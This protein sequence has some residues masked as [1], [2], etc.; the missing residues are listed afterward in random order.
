MTEDHFKTIRMPYFD[1]HHIGGAAALAP[2]VRA[3]V[4][5]GID[6]TDFA[7]NNFLS[8]KFRV[9]V[10]EV[11]ASRGTHPD[12]Q[13]IRKLMPY[14]QQASNA[15]VTINMRIGQGYYVQTPTIAGEVMSNDRVALGFVKRVTG[16]VKEVLTALTP[17]NYIGQTVYAL[18]DGYGNTLKNIVKLGM[19]NKIR[20]FVN[21]DICEL[22]VAKMKTMEYWN[23]LD[24]DVGCLK[25]FVMDMNLCAITPGSHV[26]ASNSAHFLTR[27]KLQGILESNST[28]DGIYMASD[29]LFDLDKTSRL[30]ASDFDLSYRPESGRVTGAIAGLPIN[31]RVLVTA[32]FPTSYPVKFIYP[33]VGDDDYSHP[34]WRSFAMFSKTRF[35][36]TSTIVKGKLGFPIKLSNAGFKASLKRKRPMMRTMAQN[37]YDWLLECGGYV[38]A[39]L[40]GLA[41]FA[42]ADNNGIWKVTLRGGLTFLPTIDLE[43]EQPFIFSNDHADQFYIELVC[44]FGKIYPFFLAEVGGQVSDVKEKATLI[45]DRLT[46]FAVKLNAYQARSP[47]VSFKSYY[48]IRSAG[49]VALNVIKVGQAN[50]RVMLPMDGVI[51]ND[52]FGNVSFFY[53]PLSTYDVLIHRVD[54]KTDDLETATGGPVEDPNKKFVGDGIYECAIHSGKHIIGCARPDKF[55]DS[56]PLHV[57]TSPLGFKMSFVNGEY[58]VHMFELNI[59]VDGLNYSNFKKGLVTAPFE[60]VVSMVMELG[61]EPTKLKYYHELITHKLSFYEMDSKGESYKT[62]DFIQVINE[63]LPMLS[64][65]YLWSA[66]YHSKFIDSPPTKSSTSLFKGRYHPSVSFLSKNYIH[67]YSWANGAFDNGLFDDRVI[68]TQGLGGQPPSDHVVDDEALYS[69]HQWAADNPMS[70]VSPDVRFAVRARQKVESQE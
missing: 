65:H 57:D 22:K 25:A 7:N 51:V 47:M 66:L 46:D 52:L 63:S 44:L 34:Y 64:P 12:Y 54:P 43:G 9:F 42:H 16:Y 18:G 2:L 56:D 32:D 4:E 58:K 70:N 68:F 27:A 28:F 62:K 26:V 38:S 10:K 36:D 49:D 5:F 6:T 11:I 23:P 14:Y 15:F 69:F 39:K 20:S 45:N 1:F 35:K 31:E 29:M 8:G 33:F 50:S 40:N 53:K 17:T 67:D 30:V 24:F 13:K 59:L 61:I 60:A 48:P 41:A 19:V 21:V 37:D 55:R 3:A